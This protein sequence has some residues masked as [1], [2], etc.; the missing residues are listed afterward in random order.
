MQAIKKLSIAKCAGKMTSKR[1]FEAGGKLAVLRVV[2]TAVGVKTGQSDYGDWTALIGDFGVTNLI[3][4]EQFRGATLFLPDVALLPIQVQLQ[5]P[6]AQAVQFALDVYAVEDDTTTVGFSYQVDHLVKAE[7]DTV[8]KLMAAAQQARP[9][10]IAA[11]KVEPI[12]SG[13]KGK[14]AA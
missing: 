6:N 1:V 12:E 5:K 3:D 8:A 13:K 4:G 9:L 14:K 11:S 7:D 2:G 10:Q